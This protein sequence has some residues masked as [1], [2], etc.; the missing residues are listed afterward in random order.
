MS[1]EGQLRWLL[2][3]SALSEVCAI[4]SLRY[5]LH[6]FDSKHSQDSQRLNPKVQI[7]GN[8]C[9]TVPR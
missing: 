6:Y 7:T 1:T 9:E 3:K 5:L 2:P 8:I 4:R